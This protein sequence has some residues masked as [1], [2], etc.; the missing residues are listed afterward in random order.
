VGDDERLGSR[1]PAI[2]LYQAVAQLPDFDV[3]RQLLLAEG[4]RIP[5]V[6]DGDFNVLF[7]STHIGITRI[8]I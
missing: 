3:L 1:S 5:F 6:D 7:G 8:A 4:W 2:I